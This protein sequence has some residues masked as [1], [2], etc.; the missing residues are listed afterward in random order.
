MLDYIE[1][2]V[3]K[4]LVLQ[5]DKKSSINLTKN[6]VLYG[7]SRH[8]EVRI[9]LPR[10]KVKQGELEVKHFSSETQLTDIFTK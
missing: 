6:L 4:P 9:H 8:T 2:K 3:K 7:R 10:E 5:I 1:V